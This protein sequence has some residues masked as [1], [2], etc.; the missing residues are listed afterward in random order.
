[1]LDRNPALLGLA[2]F[3]AASVP[4]AEMASA[5]GGYGPYFGLRAGGVAVE[6]AE[7]DGVEIDYDTG[8]AISGQ[9][10]Y[11]FDIFRLEGE[12][13]YQGLEGLSSN[14][15]NSDVDV[16]R[17]TLNG[18]VDLPITPQFGPYV[19]GGFGIA[20]LSADGDFEDEDS[21][22]TWHAE[23]GLNFNANRQFVIS[24]FYRYQEIDTDLGQQSEPLSAHLFGVSLRYNLTW[25]GRRHRHSHYHAGRGW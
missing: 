9:I 12:F 16:G 1:M 6:D 7:A 21:A 11:Q 8:F 14:N 20:E 24:P 15:V 4:F 5:N 17:F 23:A 3:A 25:L 13:G 18:Y 19:G 2:L 22:F 10:G